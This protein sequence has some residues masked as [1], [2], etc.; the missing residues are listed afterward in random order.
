M[1]Y[2]SSVIYGI[3][4]ERDKMTAFIAA[5]RLQRPDLHQAL[6][7]CTLIADGDCLVLGV[8]F[9]G[10][11]WYSGYA[12]VDCHNSLYSYAEEHAEE[13]ELDGRFC[14][15][16]EDAKDIEEEAFGAD[17]YDIACVATVV[18]T[19]YDFSKGNDIRSKE[20]P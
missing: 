18:E 8:N 15:A 9:G 19:A 5:A 2:T 6:D 11:K 17:P 16:G 20:A 4:G 10:V 7:E 14:R 13:F 3:R 12:D 1:G